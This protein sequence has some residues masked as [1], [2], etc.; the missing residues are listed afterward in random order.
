M[1]RWGALYSLIGLNLLW[2]QVKYSNEFLKIGVGARA[3]A[4]GNAQVA[5]SEDVT[6]AYWNPAALLTLPSYP[7]LALMHSEYFASVA[8]YDYG[9]LAF[10]IQENRRFAISFIRLGIDDIP[11][12]LRFYDG[13]SYDFSRITKFSVADM[14]LYL[15]YAQPLRDTTLSIGGSVKV[16]H[17]VLGPFATAWGFGLDMG[18][19]YRKG[20]WRLGAALY[21][22]TSTFNAWTFNTETFEEAFLLTGN[23]IPQNSIEWTRPSARIGAAVHLWP[24][25]RFSVVPTADMVIFTDGP[26]NTLLPGRPLSADL[27]LGTEVRYRSW[28]ALRIG[29]TNFQK[30]RRWDGR[31]YLTFYPTAGI[32]I[33]VWYFTI[34]YALANFTGF[35]QGLYSHLISLRVDLAPT[36]TRRI[37]AKGG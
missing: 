28:V 24:E 12:T 16:I 6:A 9:A 3:A 11:N 18:L 7:Q 34:D 36:L 2:G 31:S 30:M 25:K 32:G 33:H 5:S 19:L 37:F 8:K 20:P 35:S 27:S 29:L 10:P 21:D 4:L 1:Y 13:S 17:R 15:S 23:A 22:A 26:R 14:A